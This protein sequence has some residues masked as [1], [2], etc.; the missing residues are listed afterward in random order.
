MRKRSGVKR[1]RR[2]QT[3]LAVSVENLFRL[4]LR[5]PLPEQ[6]HHFPIRPA[7]TLDLLR[8]LTRGAVDLDS[9][10]DLDWL[11]QQDLQE[12]PDQ[13]DTDMRGRLQGTN[14]ATT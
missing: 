9:D 2:L 6:Q 7:L 5:L 11:E 13:E 3:R 10:L 14:L 8:L 4:R 1:R 12:Q